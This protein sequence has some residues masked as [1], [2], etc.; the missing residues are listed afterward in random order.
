MIEIYYKKSR[1]LLDL[2][3]QE[4]ITSPNEV[5]QQGYWRGGTNGIIRREDKK[6]AARV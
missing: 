5:K 4:S 3:E 1:V 2:W 6:F